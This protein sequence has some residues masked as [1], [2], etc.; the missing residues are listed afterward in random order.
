MTAICKAEHFEIFEVSGYDTRMVQMLGALADLK[1]GLRRRDGGREVS[2]TMITAGRV[3]A[4]LEVE[5]REL[6]SSR[7][8][9]I[10]DES[11]E[12]QRLRETDVDVGH[13]GQQ[14]SSALP[15]RPQAS[16]D[17]IL[18]ARNGAADEARWSLLGMAQATW[19]KMTAAC[20]RFSR[21]KDLEEDLQDIFYSLAPHLLILVTF[22]LAAKTDLCLQAWK[23][24]TSLRI[25]AY[26]VGL[27]RKSNHSAT[28]LADEVDETAPLPTTIACLNCKKSKIR[29]ATVTDG[30]CRPCTQCQQKGLKCEYPDPNKYPWLHSSQHDDSNP[31]DMDQW[32]PN[33]VPTP[34]TPPSAGIQAFLEDRAGFPRVGDGSMPHAGPSTAFRRDYSSPRPPGTMPIPTQ[35]LPSQLHGQPEG[36]SS[37]HQLPQYNPSAQYYSGVLPSIGVQNLFNPLYTPTYENIFPPQTPDQQEMVYPAAW[38]QT[39]QSSYPQNYNPNASGFDQHR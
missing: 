18:G 10:L 16:S 9:T 1:L 7:G 5:R 14:Q 8:G 28:I 21:S 3:S 24:G 36:F 22:N 27:I 34:I 4:E 35:P 38:T 29:C 2:R 13:V 19:S 30:N 6:Y 39:S 20:Q 12:A 17:F 23:S 31:L 11:V 15:S 26:K 33:Q 37:N 32:D 25:R